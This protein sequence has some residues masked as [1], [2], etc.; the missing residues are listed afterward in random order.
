M[1][2]FVKLRS[3]VLGLALAGS[4]AFIAA[5]DEAKPDEASQS[6]QNMSIGEATD[7]MVEDAG[8]VG[9]KAKEIGSD[10]AEGAEDAYDSTKEALQEATE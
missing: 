8:K 6:D 2:E 1:T 3:I 4:V 7:N 10:T 5:A 9:E